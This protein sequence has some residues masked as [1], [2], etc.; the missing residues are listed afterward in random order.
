MRTFRHVLPV[1]ALALLTVCVLLWLF[2][3]PLRAETAEAPRLAAEAPAPS[4]SAEVVEPQELGEIDGLPAEMPMSHQEC[5]FENISKP[6]SE[7]PATC[8]VNGEDLP[9]E[10][11]AFTR[12]RC[13]CPA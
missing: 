13:F 8:K 5:F 2:G 3:A 4:C 11:N 9:C 6:C 10:C 1:P 7:C 12:F